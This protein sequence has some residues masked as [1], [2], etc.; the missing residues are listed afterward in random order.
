MSIVLATFACIAGFSLVVWVFCKLVYPERSQ[1]EV[2]TSRFK[3]GRPPTDERFMKRY[4][5]NAAHAHAK[6]CWLADG[7]KHSLKARVV[8]LSD[9]GAR[10]KSRVPLAPETSVVLEMPSLLL[11]GT[12]KVRYCQRTNL[13]YSVG[14]SFHGPLFRT[15]S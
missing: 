8:D 2:L 5:P 14:L 9:D 1:T 3:D 6:V 7:R 10:I 11:A 15:P 12:A 13:A 4:E